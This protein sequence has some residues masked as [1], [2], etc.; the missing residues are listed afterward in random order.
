MTE[1]MSGLTIGLLA[2]GYWLLAVGFKLFS[3]QQFSNLAI[4]QFTI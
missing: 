2:V 1:P 4:Q 3:I